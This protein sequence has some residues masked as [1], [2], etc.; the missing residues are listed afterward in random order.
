MFVHNF[1]LNFYLK[2]TFFY[3]HNTI[4]KKSEIP[5]R[6]WTLYLLYSDIAISSCYVLQKIHILVSN[7]TVRLQGTLYSFIKQHKSRKKPA[8]R[9]EMDEDEIRTL[10]PRV[11]PIIPKVCLF[12]L[13]LKL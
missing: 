13:G 7:P 10:I 9:I 4:L 1:Y 12:I 2:T 5:K 6:E 3:K 11:S 8:P